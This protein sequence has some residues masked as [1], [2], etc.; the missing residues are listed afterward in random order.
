VRI[1][2][3]PTWLVLNVVRRH[4]AIAQ[5]IFFENGDFGFLM[6]FG[7]VIEFEGGMCWGVAG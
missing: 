4:Q 3:D 6:M 1:A 2:G 5:D 7:S